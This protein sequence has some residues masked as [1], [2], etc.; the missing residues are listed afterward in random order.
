MERI[1]QAIEN[2]KKPEASRAGRP[3]RS[4]VHSHYAKETHTDHWYSLE[5]VK[6]VAAFVLILFA[7]W[8]W[9]R[10]DFMN[11]LELIAS[12]YIHDGVKQ[13]RAEAKKRMDDEANFKKLI[14][15]NL[16]HCQE[17]AEKNKESYL[18]LMQHTVQVKNTKEKHAAHEQFIVPKTAISQANKMLEDAKA[19]CQQIYDR[20][21]QNGR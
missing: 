13:A 15:T 7:G 1:K 2:A 9:M 11:R 17:A 10:L 6:I 19:E 18:Q 3:D 5:K 8:L 16:T 21:L 4:H 12:E 14:L 20:Q